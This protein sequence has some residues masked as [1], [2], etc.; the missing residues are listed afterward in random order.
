MPDFIGVF[1]ADRVPPQRN[2]VEALILN[3]DPAGTVG[4]HWCALYRDGDRTVIWDSFGRSAKDLFPRID[5]EDCDS[6]QEQAFRENWCGAGCLAWLQV[7][8]ALG[9]DAAKRV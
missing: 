5:A 1:P 8:A 4:T 6:D 2:E 7:A 9:L 3:T